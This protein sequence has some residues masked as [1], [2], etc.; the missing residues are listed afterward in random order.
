MSTVAV[1]WAA[2]VRTPNTDVAA[3]NAVQTCRAAGAGRTGLRAAGALLAGP[4]VHPH[5]RGRH[6]GCGGGRGGGAQS[7]VTLDGATELDQVRVSGPRGEGEDGGGRAGRGG[8][9]RPAI[10]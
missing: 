1:V 2:D 4:R 7:D 9:P 10:G 5:V 6:R 8:S 3:A